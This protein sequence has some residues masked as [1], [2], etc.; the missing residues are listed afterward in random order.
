MVEQNDVIF[1]YTR[2][3]ALKDGVLMYAGPTAPERPV[4]GSLSP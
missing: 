2:A 3:D 1:R 4:S